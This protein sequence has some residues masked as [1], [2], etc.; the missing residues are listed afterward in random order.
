M[1]LNPFLVFFFFLGELNQI[2]CGCLTGIMATIN[3]L[4]PE[5][6]CGRSCGGDC[7]WQ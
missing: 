7:V 1:W 3:L 2:L 4:V 6:G 5:L